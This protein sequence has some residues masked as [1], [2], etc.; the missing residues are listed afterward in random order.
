MISLN[1]GGQLFTTT[2]RTLTAIP[3]G[4]LHSMFS[5][6]WTLEWSLHQGVPSVFIDRSGHTMRHVLN[7]LRHEE[8]LTDAV[9][10]LTVA[11]LERY[12]IP[13]KATAAERRRILS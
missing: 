9:P 3:V 1:V 10:T 5:G 13:R 4:M 7:Y 8:A 6:R 11:D 12:K 2:L